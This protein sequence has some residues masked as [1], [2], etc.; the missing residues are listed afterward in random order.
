LIFAN[1]TLLPDTERKTVLD[2][3]ET[4]LNAV[5]AA[6]PLEA[7]T[8]IRAVDALGKR[9][10]AGE[11][12]PLLARFLP[13]GVGLDQLLPLL[14]REALEAKLAAE[15]GPEPFRPVKLA[16]TTARA[17]PLGVLFHIAPWN[18]PGNKI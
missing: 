1:G 5:R 9:L 8:V 4:Q 11:F 16:K 14:R 15:L 13:A 6:P 10:E 17:L 7:E 12:A 3:L 2:S 18:M